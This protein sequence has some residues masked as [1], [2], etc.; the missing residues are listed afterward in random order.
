MRAVE[1][2]VV[3]YS[4]M[5]F[6]NSK[7]RRVIVILFVSFMLFLFSVF[8]LYSFIPP[9]VNVQPIHVNQSTV[10]AHQL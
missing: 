10:D 8:I 7:H 2:R 6:P 4:L 5:P 3:N 9:A 1:S